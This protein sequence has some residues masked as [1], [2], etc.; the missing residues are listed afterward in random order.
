MKLQAKSRLMARGPGNNTVNDF[1][2][3]MG[4]LAAGKIPGRT[5]NNDCRVTVV[6]AL[7]HELEKHDSIVIVG[8][9]GHPVHT[10]TIGLNGQPIADSYSGRY[11]DGVYTCTL[12]NGE[13]ADLQ[14]LCII[15]VPDFVAKY[16][17][18]LQLHGHV[19][20][21]PD[22]I[23]AKCG[24]PTSRLACAMCAREAN[25]LA[26]DLHPLSSNSTINKD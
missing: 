9:E 2:T 19:V 24:G 21:R 1:L 5:S 11:H 7:A 20:P 14:T 6:R 18:P 23:R 15:S 4:M 22:G 17:D 25:L 3:K 13:A 12:S 8:D 16:V 10:F 26:A